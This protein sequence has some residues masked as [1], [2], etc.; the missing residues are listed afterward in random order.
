MHKEWEVA[1]QMKPPLRFIQR[2]RMSL[3]WGSPV[4]RDMRWEVHYQ[5]H[6]EEESVKRRERRGV[7]RGSR[8]CSI[9]PEA[10]CDF[11]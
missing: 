1:E 7:A 3:K 11:S 2:L 9:T 10:S 4:I 5:H 8:G 6:S